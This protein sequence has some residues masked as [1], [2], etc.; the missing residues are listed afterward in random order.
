MKTLITNS[1]SWGASHITNMATSVSD[2]TPR[3]GSS[4]G[5]LFDLCGITREHTFYDQ[6]Y[7][8]HHSKIKAGQCVHASGD[9]CKAVHLVFSGFLKNTWTDKDGPIEFLNRHE[10]ASETL[11]LHLIT[12]MSK[13]LVNEQKILFVTSC[14][15]ADAR[16]AKFLL[17][18]SFKFKTLGFSEK[19]FLLRMK[20]E[21]IGS[22]LGLTNETVSRTLSALC[23]LGLMKK[24]NRQ[25]DIL[26]FDALMKFRRLPANMNYGRNRT[27]SVSYS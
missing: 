27:K 17:S 26:D 18:L 25:I 11:K 21:D 10:I 3:T 22:H 19:S 15:P 9:E 12:E 13:Q 7:R 24:N 4:I 20:Q 8:F 5:Q 14:L 2:S 23:D 1:L 16:V 6:N